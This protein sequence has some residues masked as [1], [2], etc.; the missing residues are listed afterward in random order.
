MSIRNDIEETGGI[1][2]G[3]E[4]VIWKLFYDGRQQ[5]NGEPADNDSEAIAAAK[6]KRD[7]LRNKFK[8]FPCYLFPDDEKWEVR[9]W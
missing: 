3:G 7:E 5:T 8:G 9:I 2:I 1:I 6:A 4:Y